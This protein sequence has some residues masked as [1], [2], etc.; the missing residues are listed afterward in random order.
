MDGKLFNLW[1]LGGVES[2]LFPLLML[3][4]GI[5]AVVFI[6]FK[7]TGFRN[8]GWGLKKWQ[9]IFP[10]IIVPLVVSLGLVYLIEALNWGV[11]S[12]KLFVFSEGMLE[13]TKI[14]LLLGNE[15]QTI[16]FFLF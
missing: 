4:P 10:A 8:I 11:P 9:Y 1:S 7:K 12:E 5:V 6:I 15:N 13:S 16:P 14:G 3:F 2:K